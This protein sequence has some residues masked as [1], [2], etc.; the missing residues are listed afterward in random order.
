[1]DNE[2][3]YMGNFYGWMKDCLYF[4]GLKFFEMDKIKIQFYY[5][6]VRASYANESIELVTD[7]IKEIIK[8]KK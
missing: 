8:E 6:K 3:I 7:D 5:G 2:G 4:F 1:M